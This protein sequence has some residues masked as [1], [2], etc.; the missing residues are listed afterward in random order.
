MKIRNIVLGGAATGLLLAFFVSCGPTTPQDCADI[1]H[2]L[3]MD[4]VFVP[5]AGNPHACD[6][7]EK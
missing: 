1:C 4:P 3:N 6:C 5:I 7:K 2:K